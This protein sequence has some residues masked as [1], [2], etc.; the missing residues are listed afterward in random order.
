MCASML[1][2][3]PVG[4]IEVVMKL[5]RCVTFDASLVVRF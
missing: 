5:V 3:V 1:F 4:N 2:L